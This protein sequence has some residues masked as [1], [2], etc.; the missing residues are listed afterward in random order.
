MNS[1]S[2]LKP[3]AA[4]WRSLG[5]MVIGAVLGGGATLLLY[6]GLR[7]LDWADAL[8]LVCSLM[9]LISAVVLALASLDRNALSRTL[10]V[11]G[12]ATPAEVRGARLQAVVL[13]LA[14]LLLIAPVI[15]EVLG[16][17]V[18]LATWLCLAALFVAQS[19]Y[20]L[21]LWRKGD[22]LVRRVILEAGALT[23]WIFQG[24]LFLYAAAERLG[25]VPAA[26]AWDL[27]SAIMAA[28]LLAGCVITL[29][30]KLA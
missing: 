22:E 4:A 28:Y 12:E 17:P 20:N 13:A 10:K 25:L 16:N 8:A 30:R 19:G 26:T 2:S 9:C 18:P 7:R 23:F 11:E 1:G 24:G 29:R 21:Q 5:R 15:A 6:V 3:P 27:F 14:G